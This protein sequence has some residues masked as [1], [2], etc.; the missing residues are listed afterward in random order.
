MRLY[1]Y[2]GQRDL[3][4]LKDAPIAR[5]EPDDPASLQAWLHHERISLPATLTFVVTSAG[6]LRVASRHAEHVV[7][8]RGAPVL[9]A[10]EIEIDLRRDI[11]IVLGV[12]NQSTGYCPEPECFSAVRAALIECGLAAPLS[13]PTRSPSGAAHRAPPAPS[14]RTPCSSAIPA[15]PSFRASGTSILRRAASLAKLASNN[16]LGST[17]KHARDLPI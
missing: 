2:V 14:P 17:I 9:V 7:C 12:T 4:E 13:S 11:L 3:L 1:H 6:R 8:A 16:A 10:G 5:C 15:A